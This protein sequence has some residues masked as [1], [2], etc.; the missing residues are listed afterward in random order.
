MG[1]TSGHTFLSVGSVWIS[2]YSRAWFIR[3]VCFSSEFGFF[4][5]CDFR[6]HGSKRTGFLAPDPSLQGPWGLFSG[7]SSGVFLLGVFWVYSI[8]VGYIYLLIS[9]LFESVLCFRLVYR[10]RDLPQESLRSREESL[11]QGASP[12][13][14]WMRG[15]ARHGLRRP[16]V[17]RLF[18][19][20]KE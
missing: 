8:S 15:G 4:W 12:Q 9:F 14:S 17:P 16:T 2:V 7:V 13:Q 10:E 11:G 6:I 5:K 20:G 19:A 3:V 18:C 1:D